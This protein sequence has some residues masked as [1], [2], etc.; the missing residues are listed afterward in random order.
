MPPKG[1]GPEPPEDLEED[2]APALADL[3]ALAAELGQAAAASEEESRVA[4]EIFDRI[5]RLS[6]DA[7]RRLFQRPAVRTLFD[8]AA[9]SE[10]AS[11]PDDPPGTIY[12]RLVGGEKTPWSKKPWTWNY[13]W[14]H[15]PTHTWEPARRLDLGFQGLLVTVFPGV[16]VTLPAVFHAIYRDHLTN[17]ALAEEHRDYLFMRRHTLRDPGMVTAGGAMSRAINNHPQEPGRGNVC[18][19]GAGWTEPFAPPESAARGA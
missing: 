17:T 7:Q 13:L 18:A 10:E 3:A 11:S 5:G 16:E 14:G 2:E 4:Q 1:R 19:P 8:R 15:F 9:E 12:Y 6:T